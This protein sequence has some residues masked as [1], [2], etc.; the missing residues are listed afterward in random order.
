MG[1]KIFITGANGFIGGHLARRLASQGEEV[2]CLVRDP[3]KA[4]GL[5]APGL[6]LV[7]GDITDKGSMRAAMK[8]SDAV[9]H[10]AGWYVIGNVDKTRM[11]AINVSGA[12]NTL[13]L[14]ADLGV[15]KILHTSTV[16]VFGN[17]HGKIVDESYRA[18]KAAMRSEY[19]LTKWMAHYEVAEP[20]QK[21]GA[22]LII[23]QPGGV[24]GAGDPAQHAL[25][26]KMFLNRIPIMM[27]ARSGLTLAHVDD[28]AEGH[29]L[30][31]EKGRP[32]EAYI[33]A[34]D[35]LTYRQVFDVCEE[36]TGMR[37]TRL[38]AP[39]WVAGFSSALVGGLEKLGVRLDF[40]AEMLATLNDYTFWAVA[41]KAK[42]E[43]G[44][45]PR[46]T[47]KTLQNVLADLQKK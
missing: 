6:T 23:I 37:G 8:G 13:E 4:A 5:K 34:G 12:K 16:G 43:L 42:R 18:P 27:G 38:W 45:A 21:Q 33:L 9:F 39:G 36:I 32:G 35:P 20:L 15:P 41:D 26:F 3:D 46:T 47:E 19:E 1:K 2:T 7:K 14:A 24:T 17:T 29:R 31:L 22:P 25:I 10:L 11:Y 28:I 30:A 40:S 44:W